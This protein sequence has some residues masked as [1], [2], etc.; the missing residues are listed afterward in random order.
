MAELD[1][2]IGTIVRLAG[3][4]GVTPGSLCE[5]MTWDEDAQRFEFPPE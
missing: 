2:E 5:G 1:T 3:A 4:P